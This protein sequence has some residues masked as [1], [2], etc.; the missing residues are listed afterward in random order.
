MFENKKHT[1]CVVNFLSSREEI[2]PDQP[3]IGAIL[4][5]KKHFY[6]VFKNSLKI[7]LYIVYL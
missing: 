7:A 4:N 6:C 2:Q 3:T 1:I 5:E